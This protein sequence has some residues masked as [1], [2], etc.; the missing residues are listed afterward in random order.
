M[1]VL[2]VE[3]PNFYTCQG[4]KNVFQTKEEYTFELDVWP[5]CSSK[6]KFLVVYHLISKLN[7]SDEELLEIQKNVEKKEEIKDFKR[8]SAIYSITKFY[9]NI[10]LSSISIHGTWDRT[11]KVGTNELAKSRDK[12]RGHHPL[13]GCMSFVP[14]SQDLVNPSI[15]N[16]PTLEIK[17]RGI[18]KWF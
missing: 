4:C 2:N 17:K 7:F 1:I 13:K 10:D 18:N 16:V 5:V 6:C 14:L 15:S 11:N 9:S 8:H 12:N 3:V